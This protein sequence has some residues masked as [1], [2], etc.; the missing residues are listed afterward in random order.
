M[1]KWAQA[2]TANTCE[3]WVIISVN[4]SAT[5]KDDAGADAGLDTPQLPEP[6]NNN[7]GC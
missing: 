7:F 1:D 3:G 6:N 5:K 4:D 2:A